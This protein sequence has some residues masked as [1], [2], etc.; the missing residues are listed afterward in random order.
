MCNLLYTDRCKIL[1]L[2][3]NYILVFISTL[4]CLAFDK[5]DPCISSD[6]TTNGLVPGAQDFA[7]LN[8]KQTQKVL[9]RRCDYNKIMKG[10][11]R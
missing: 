7:A 4:Y 3:K 8:L 5:F 6:L 2:L 10:E 11:R 9:M 1:L